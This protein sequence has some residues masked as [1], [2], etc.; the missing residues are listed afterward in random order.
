[1]SFQGA[2]RGR[3]DGLQQLAGVLD[4]FS[5]DQ[6]AER[7]VRSQAENLSST[8]D[9]T[10]HLVHKSQSLAVWSGMAEPGNGVAH[11][12]LCDHS[13][14]HRDQHLGLRDSSDEYLETA[15][16]FVEFSFRGVHEPRVCLDA[17][18]RED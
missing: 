13:A 17:A 1:M 5:A 11:C 9:L 3:D 7:Y 18:A 15:R 2:V 4:T 14:D 8:Q 6:I 12:R 16:P 10:D